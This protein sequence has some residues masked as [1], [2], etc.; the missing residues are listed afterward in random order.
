MITIPAAGTLWVTDAEYKLEKYAVTVDSISLGMTSDFA[1]N[2]KLYCDPSN[3]GD[4]CIDLGFSNG[5]FP[6]NAGTHEVIIAG[7]GLDPGYSY[8]SGL[9]KVEEKCD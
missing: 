8:F 4:K 3:A 2:P 6:I 7:V 5:K 9:Y 1:A